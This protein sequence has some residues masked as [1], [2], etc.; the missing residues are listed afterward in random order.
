MPPCQAQPGCQDQSRLTTAPGGCQNTNE[1][2]HFNNFTYYVRSSIR[3]GHT[4]G[5]ARGDR[6]QALRRTPCQLDI[7]CIYPVIFRCP[8]PER[9]L[10]MRRAGIEI[11]R[12]EL[13]D[14]HSIAWVGELEVLDTTD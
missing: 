13:N 2:Y 1:N 9:M 14:R 8:M 7:L 11:P 10:K 3:L 6:Q 5:S 4:R 12:R